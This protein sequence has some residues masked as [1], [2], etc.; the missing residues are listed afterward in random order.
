MQKSNFFVVSFGLA[1]SALATTADA[2][3]LSKSGSVTRAPG[4]I[5]R[6]GNAVF[7]NGDTAA[8]YRNTQWD[9]QAGTASRDISNTYRDGS[10]RSVSG[11]ATRLE[12]GVFSAQRTAVQRDGDTVSTSKT[13]QRRY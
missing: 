1:L 12:P 7:A 11:T 10:T 3:V 5:T 8:R 13:I 6:V 4:E 9:R 2:R